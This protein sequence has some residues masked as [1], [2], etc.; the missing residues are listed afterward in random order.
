LTHVRPAVSRLDLALCSAQA[1]GEKQLYPPSLLLGQIPPPPAASPP[2]RWLALPLDPTNLP[3]KGRIAFSCVIAGNPITE[4]SFAG[5]LVDEWNERIPT[6][7]ENA[8]ISFH[9]KEASGRAPQALLLA[10]CPDNRE[11]WDAALLEAIL[12][13]TIELARIRTVDLASIERV[14][15]ILPALYFALNLQGSTLS[16]RFVKEQEIRR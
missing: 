3:Q 4:S 2:D 10:V 6:T 13:E 5:L 7:Q 14:G 8:A 1:F 16:T 11:F 12:Q 9:F 15:Q